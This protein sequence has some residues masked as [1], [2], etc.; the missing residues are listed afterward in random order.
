MA[1]AVKS[2]LLVGWSVVQAGKKAF[3]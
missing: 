2:W 1:S 3:V